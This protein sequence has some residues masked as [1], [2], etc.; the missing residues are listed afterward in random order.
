LWPTHRTSERRWHVKRV[1]IKDVRTNLARTHIII[2]AGP[3]TKRLIFS[4]EYYRRRSVDWL[5]SQP[6]FEDVRTIQPQNIEE[7]RDALIGR[8]VKVRNVT[9]WVEVG[10]KGVEYHYTIT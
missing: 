8:Y 10:K 9:S 4:S 1:R 6:W 3:Y 2:R 5:L 7:W